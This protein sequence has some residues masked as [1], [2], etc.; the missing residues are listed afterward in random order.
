MEYVLR[1][2]EKIRLTTGYVINP[3]LLQYSVECPYRICD[4]PYMEQKEIEKEVAKWEKYNDEDYDTPTMIAAAVL[5]RNLRILHEHQILHNAIHSQNYTWALELLDFELAC[6]PRHP[7]DD[8]QSQRMVKDLFS[9]EIIQTYEIINHI[10][11]CLND[12]IDY[13]RVDKLFYDNG[14]DLSALTI[15]VKP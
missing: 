8:E 10:A 15:D 14:F 2:D 6:S 13:K 9:R 3:I 1:L 5:V 12:E 7:Y 4:A 11:W